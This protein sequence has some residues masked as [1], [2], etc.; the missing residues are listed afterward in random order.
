MPKKK[1][2]LTIDEVFT[3]LDT[4]SGR[5]KQRLLGKLSFSMDGDPRVRKVI[6]KDIQSNIEKIK[7][8]PVC[9]S[10]GSTIIIKKGFKNNG[11]QRFQCTDCNRKFTSVTDTF[12]EKTKVSWGV[13]VEIIHHMLL[14][15]SIKRSKESLSEEYG[16]K[17]IRQSTIYHLRMKVMNAAA[18]VPMPELVGVI[19]TDETGFHEAQKGRAPL[20]DPID[21]TTTRDARKRAEASAYGALGPEFGTALCAVDHTGHVVIK[22]K[23]VGATTV[24]EFE[25]LIGPYIKNVSILCSDNNNIYSSYCAKHHI[26]HY[27]RPSNYVETIKKAKKN[28]TSL[29]LLYRSE[30]LDYIV[31]TRMERLPY[32]EFRKIKKENNLSLSSVNGLHSRLKAS[33]KSAAHGVD[34]KNLDK[35]LAWQ[36]FIENY[37]ADY[38]NAPTTW[39]DAENILIELI[40]VKKNITLEEIRSTRPDFT[41]LNQHFQKRLIEKTKAVSKK[42]KS[43]SK[44]YLGPD[45]IS[46][47]SN[48]REHLQNLP[49]YKLVYLARKLKIPGRSHIKKDRTWAA[50]TAMER[51]P[52]LKNALDDMSAHFEDGKEE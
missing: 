21:P 29:S 30:K 50:V 18:Y 12:L 48:I 51:H 38:G 4:A 40:K 13:W 49:V 14:G 36:C 24:D 45:D 33:L 23:G 42:K 22:Y 52:D 37:R 34:T 11:L 17:G 35:Y 15:I 47:D 25:G 28:K 41:T 46:V 2:E 10:C 7:I 31:G 16:L 43:N 19:E 8:R 6:G 32:E 9:P 44:T 5:E 20:I 1:T 27:I 39:K 3:W 26:V